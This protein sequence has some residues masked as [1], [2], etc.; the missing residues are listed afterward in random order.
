MSA[1][2]VAR[3]DL[4]RL[5]VRPFAWTLAAIALGALAW[6]F[7]QNLNAFLIAQPKL[8]ASANGPGY[9]DLVAVPHLLAYVQL[10]L[11]LAP[12]ITMHAIAGERR[13]HT[14]PLL[15]ASG[16]SPARIVLGKYVSSLIY[17]WLLLVLVA[18]MPVLLA[19]ATTPDWGQFDAA[20]LGCALCIAALA[21]IGVA[22]SAFSTH[23]AVAAIAALLIVLILAML[24]TGGHLTGAGIGWL[25]YLALP[26][27]LTPFMH[28][29]VASVDI[30]Y[31]L[32][33]IALALS[34]A[35]RRMAAEKVRG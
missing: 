24:G 9:T 5:L 1:L 26:T 16:L 21:A 28:G 23:P 14:L 13:A 10:C 32:L 2:P 7:L 4:Q 30:V 20:L 15:F 6:M 18:L 25:A 12:L 19:R 11:L 35:I 34:F 29:L 8:A 33:L 17:L 31:F 22:A 27:H 3:L